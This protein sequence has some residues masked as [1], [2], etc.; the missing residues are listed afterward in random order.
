ML[1]ARYRVLVPVFSAEL[2]YA[3]SVHV[4]IW[5]AAGFQAT[6]KL[7]AQMFPVA[8][9]RY[10]ST[11]KYEPIG[12]VVDGNENVFPVGVPEVAW[13]NRLIDIAGAC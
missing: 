10:A 11:L 7:H 3:P 9:W 6:F 12:F 13:F 2:R 8:P 4:V 5:I 1:P